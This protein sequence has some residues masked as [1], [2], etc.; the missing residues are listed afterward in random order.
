M[1]PEERSERGLPDFYLLSNGDIG[2]ISSR[3]A[4]VVA[5]CDRKDAV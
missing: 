3:V 1:P 2:D 4:R 5:R